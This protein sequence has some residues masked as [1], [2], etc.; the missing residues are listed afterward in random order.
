MNK[1]DHPKHADHIYELMQEIA[2]QL[3]DDL[4]GDVKIA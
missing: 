4:G 1:A 3:A 2:Y